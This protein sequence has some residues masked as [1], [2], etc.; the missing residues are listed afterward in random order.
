MSLQKKQDIN[1][2]LMLKSLVNSTCYNT[3]INVLNSFLPIA[4]QGST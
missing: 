4:L 1:K 3:T 2:T